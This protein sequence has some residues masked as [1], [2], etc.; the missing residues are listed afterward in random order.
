MTGNPPTPEAGVAV[1]APVP[2][3]PTS[4][5]A[6]IEKLSEL[7][8]RLIDAT[9]KSKS[10]QSIALESR[11]TLGLADIALMTGLSTATAG[12]RNRDR[13]IPAAR[14][15]GREKDPLETRY[16]QSLDRV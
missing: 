3:R 16:G 15:S 10:A 14:R 13:E 5:P 8:E 9:L 12:T 2:S 1:E 6:A 4:L 11:L 7:I